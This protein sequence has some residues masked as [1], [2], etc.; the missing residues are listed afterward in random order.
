MEL[1]ACS[2]E[3]LVIGGDGGIPVRSSDQTRI[4]AELAEPNAGL[5]ERI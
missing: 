3:N 2:M 1:R 4:A 5:K